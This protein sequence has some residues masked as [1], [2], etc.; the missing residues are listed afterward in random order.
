M[1]SPL[2]ELMASSFSLCPRVHLLL[3]DQVL[4]ND[5]IEDRGRYKYLSN[6]SNKLEREII[7]PNKII[8]RNVI[9]NLD[10]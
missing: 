3:S 6:S 5:P 7:I 8:D 4:A 2:S 9:F 10:P 1:I